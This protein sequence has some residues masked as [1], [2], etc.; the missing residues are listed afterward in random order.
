MD[1]KGKKKE[2]NLQAAFA[3]ESQARNRYIFSGQIARKAGLNDVADVFFELAETEGEHARQWFEFLG[4][5]GDVKANIERAIQGEHL[6]KENT[7]PKFAKTAR[8]EGFTEIADF[9]EKPSSWL[10]WVAT[11]SMDLPAVEIT[12]ILCFLKSC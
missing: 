7:Y 9:F 8:Q 1:L 11:S 5:L 6:E 10:T 4:G 3:G 2:K 12:G